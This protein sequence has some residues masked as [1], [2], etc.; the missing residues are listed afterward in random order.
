MYKK[1][2]LFYFIF[3][4][5]VLPFMSRAQLSTLDA[6]NIT[7]TTPSQN[8]A[9]SM[10]CGG[11]GIG[12]NVWVE[13]GSL[14]L[15]LQQS[16]WFDMNNTALKAGRIKIDIT[17]NPLAG[18]LF[19]QSLVLKDGAIVIKGQN[20][21][22]TA[23]LRVWVDMH[24][25]LVHIDIESS[26]QVAV[27]AAYESWRY[28]NR[29]LSGKANNANS[30]KWVK[31]VQVVAPKDSV[32]YHQNGVVFYH[33]NKDSSIFDFAVK[34]QHLEKEASKIWNPLQDFIGG[35]YMF[36]T[37]MKPYQNYE[38][39]YAGTD[40][41]GWSL[42]SR[43]PSIS[44]KIVVYL[45]HDTTTNAKKWITTLANNAISNNKM[46]TPEAAANWWHAFWNRSYIHVASQHPNVENDKINS[47]A[48]FAISRNYQL[49]R[50]LLACNAGGSYPTKFNGGL[51]TVDPVFTDSSIK[52]TPDH[53]NWGGGTFTAQNQRLVYW[54]LL[55]SGDVDI[56]TPQFN[57]YKNL[58]P[59][60]E[61]RSQMYWHHG[62]ASF[63][64]Q[65]ENFGLPNPAEYGFKRPDS[66]DYGVEYN[67][68]LEYEWDTV[69]EFCLMILEAQSYSQYNIQTYLPLIK[70]C[71]Q[72]F[73]EHYRYEAKKRGQPTLDQN[74]HLVFF[75][76]SG[77]ETFKLATNPSSTIAALQTVTKKLLSTTFLTNKERIYF[78]NFLQKIPPIP[79]RVINGYTT[80]APAQ[81][82]ERV[83]NTESP[84]L[85]PVFPYGI[86]GIGKPGLDTAI[87]TY[88]YDTLSVKFRSHVGWKQDNIFAARLGLTSEAARLTSFKFANSNQRFPAFWGPGFDWTPDHNH[89]GSAMIGLQEMLLQTDGDIIRL[90]P[91]WPKNWDVHYK[92]H[93]PKQTTIEIEYKAGK[94]VK[95]L[96]W[97]AARKKD[98]VIALS[99]AQ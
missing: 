96:V 57:F 19:V 58:L 65:M 85:Y 11:G 70:S 29:P 89:G 77:A 83:N 94:I 75:P 69:L 13:N 41:K 88:L 64:E 9:A 73:D 80:I 93:A 31:N 61:L 48:V 71:L 21:K 59:V 6:Y 50:Y 40:F 47:D 51:F 30:W 32:Y 79:F 81:K 16:G 67:K 4:W 43:T 95:L 74:G 92:L 82:W 53:R 78:Q 22:L 46:S 24:K 42:Q 44:N 90:L 5:A 56:M 97:P 68:W 86:F 66:A 14:Y 10:P 34:Q 18:Q 84:Q 3:S 27:V 17:P 35:G 76:G 72:F 39:S 55:K 60:A 36:G 26:Q 33:H 12:A 45:K 15:Y 91:S 28:K 87:H 62:G 98:V 1:T 38:G 52:A 54:P 25:A 20:E 63:T 49:F 2:L 7:W 37:N 8:A 23:S 99:D